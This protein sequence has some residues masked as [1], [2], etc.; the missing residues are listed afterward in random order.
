VL[1]GS[2][3][4]G[5]RPSGHCQRSACSWP[6]ALI[7]IYGSI[8][9]HHEVVKANAAAVAVSAAAAAAAGALLAVDSICGINAGEHQDE[10]WIKQTLQFRCIEISRF[11]NL[12]VAT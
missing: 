5:S 8:G 7:S 3:A 4:P 9:Q 12:T 11:G 1:R 6:A 10:L 2:G